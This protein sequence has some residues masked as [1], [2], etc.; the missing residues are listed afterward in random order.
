MLETIFLIIG[1]PLV[2][3]GMGILLCCAVVM[4]DAVSV[5]CGGRRA[6]RIMRGRV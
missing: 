6:E 5:Y 2:Y 3:V 1:F 4:I